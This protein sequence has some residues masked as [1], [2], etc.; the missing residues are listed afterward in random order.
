VDTASNENRWCVHR[1]LDGN[2]GKQQLTHGFRAG[3]WFVA[4]FG[5]EARGSEVADR[6]MSLFHRRLKLR[7]NAKISF[8]NSSRILGD[9]EK[10]I[11]ISLTK[12]KR[13]AADI[14]HE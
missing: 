2:K 7:T 5:N 3:P 13:Q 1:P 6:Q 10:E 12:V 8:H 9:G 4:T 14:G 11:Q